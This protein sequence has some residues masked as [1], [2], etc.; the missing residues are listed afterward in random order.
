[1]DLI[2]GQIGGP[3]IADEVRVIGRADGR[4][5]EPD[6]VGAGGEI[7]GLDEFGQT[8]IRGGGI[9]QCAWSLSNRHKVGQ[10][11]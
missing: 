6:T 4:R 5:A 1:M 3:V 10:P 8:G 9:L 2:G 7:R 11:F